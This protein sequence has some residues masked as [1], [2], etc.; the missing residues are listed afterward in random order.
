M[1]RVRLDIEN[2][3]AVTARFSDDQTHL[4]NEFL[5]NF[6]LNQQVDQKVGRIVELLEAQSS[7]WQEGQASQLDLSSVAAPPYRRRRRTKHSPKKNVT[8]N[9]TI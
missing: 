6:A 3:S 4:R 8:G 7:R 9:R 2:L 5:Q 1:V